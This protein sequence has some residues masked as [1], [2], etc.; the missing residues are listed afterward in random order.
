MPKKAKPQ[1]DTPKKLLLVTWKDTY[2]DDEIHTEEQLQTENSDCIIHTVGFHAGEDE[3][4]VKV[5]MD[6]SPNGCHF[7]HVCRIR[8]ENIQ[9]I[10]EIS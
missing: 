5:G 2:Y 1:L 8:R 4:V 6:W 9:S 10:Q 3:N 7:R